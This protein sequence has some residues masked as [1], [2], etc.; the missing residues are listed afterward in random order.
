[1][2]RQRGRYRRFTDK[3]GKRPD[4]LEAE[5]IF[6]GKIYKG[7]VENLSIYTKLSPTTIYSLRDDNYK[8]SKCGWKFKTINYR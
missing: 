2:A 8:E 3:A 1:M 6:T 4:I 7:T 5:N